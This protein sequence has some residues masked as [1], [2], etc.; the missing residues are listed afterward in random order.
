M[1]EKEMKRRVCNL[2]HVD[3]SKHIGPFLF[4]PSVIYAGGQYT[5]AFGRAAA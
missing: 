5:I 4:I 3:V 2:K 1:L